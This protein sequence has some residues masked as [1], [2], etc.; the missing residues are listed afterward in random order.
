MANDDILRK[1]K[2]TWPPEPELP[3]VHETEL[4]KKKRKIAEREIGAP[5]QEEG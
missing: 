1:K 2:H 3:D 5:K 4:L